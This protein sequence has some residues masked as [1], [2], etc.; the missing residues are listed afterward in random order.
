MKKR[1]DILLDHY[2]APPKKTSRWTSIWPAQEK[3]YDIGEFRKHWKSSG[4]EKNAG[5]WQD[6]F[7]GSQ[8]AAFGMINHNCSECQAGGN[9][10]SRSEVMC[11]KT[12]K[13]G[14]WCTW[15]G[16]GVCGASQVRN[17]AVDKGSLCWE[18][19]LRIAVELDR[20]NGFSQWW[21]MWQNNPKK[22]LVFKLGAT[23]EDHFKPQKMS[24]RRAITHAW[25]LPKICSS[26]KECPRVFL[27]SDSQTSLHGCC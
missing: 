10:S 21:C 20:V 19:S 27:L 6:G 7:K 12:H 18:A 24:V 9:V 8:A 3:L 1:K 4:L 11:D 23:Y 26:P 17:D 2:H 25:A 14:D 15:K 13:Q 22:Q 16:F 5:R